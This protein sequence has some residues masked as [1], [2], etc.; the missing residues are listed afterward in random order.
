MIGISR[1]GTRASLL[2]FLVSFSASAA[3]LSLD[4]YLSQVDGQSRDIRSAREASEGA[5]LRASEATLVYSPML[6]ADAQWLNDHI[7]EL[8]VPREQIQELLNTRTW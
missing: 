6:S 1:F 8:P 2:F 7:D 4:S 3:T 5:G